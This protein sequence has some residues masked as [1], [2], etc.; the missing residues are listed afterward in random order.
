M[1]HIG[2]VKNKKIKGNKIKELRFLSED[3]IV[4]TLVNGHVIELY[5]VGEY[6]YESKIYI[7]DKEKLQC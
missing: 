4:I 5:S 3:K 6:G 2:Q 1:R 7:T